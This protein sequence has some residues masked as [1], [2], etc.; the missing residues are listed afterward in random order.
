MAFSRDDGD[1]NFNAYFEEVLAHLGLSNLSDSEIK[2]TVISLGTNTSLVTI[3][4][5]NGDTFRSHVNCWIFYR[6]FSINS[7]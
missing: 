5:N 7:C 6:L 1:D 2:F 4:F 3:K